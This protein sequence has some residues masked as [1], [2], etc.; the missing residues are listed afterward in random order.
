MSRG[1]LWV[2]A[3][4]VAAV[5]GCGGG[6]DKPRSAT[7]TTAAAP[8]ATATATEAP[9][10]KIAIAPADLGACA[11]LYVRLQRVSAAISS[12][13]ELLTQAQN[14]D[15]LSRGILTQQ[16]QLERSAALMDAAV[17]PKPLAAANRQLVTALRAFARDFAKARGPAKRGDFTA[18]STAMS[19][20]SAVKRIVASTQAIETACKP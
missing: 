11:S 5:A 1:V 4:T 17:V 16:R 10:E 15:D 13:S 8:T 3:V 12:G 7:P 20:Q 6:S 2:L 14:Q 18:A 19:D 9:L